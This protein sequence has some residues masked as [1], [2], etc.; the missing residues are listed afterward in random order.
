MKVERTVRVATTRWGGMIY[1][2]RVARG[3]SCAELARACKLSPACVTIMETGK[4]QNP[5][6]ETIELLAA[7][8]GMKASELVKTYEQQPPSNEKLTESRRE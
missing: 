2:L 4:R 8:L 6:L 1:K 5:T 7:A 3:M